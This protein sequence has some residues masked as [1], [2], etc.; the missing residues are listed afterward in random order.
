LCPPPDVLTGREGQARRLLPS[1]TGPVWWDVDFF[2]LRQG[3]GL[4]AVLGR[5]RAVAAPAADDRSMEL[6]PAPLPEKL[7][8][9]RQLTARRYGLRLLVGESPLVGCLA[10]QVRLAAAVTAPVLLVGPPGC[11]KRTVARVIHY[12]SAGRERAFAVL[13]AAR[14]PPVALAA[15]L[16]TDRSVGTVYI[17]EPARLPREFQ[18]KLAGLLTEADAEHPLPRLLAG[19]C[20]DPLEEVRAGHLLDELYTSFSALTIPVPPLT[21]RRE[22]LPRLV[23]AMLERLHEDGDRVVRG[24]TPE[25]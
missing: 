18:A 14:L 16:F 7:L 2:P 6:G 23:T 19:C 25:A 15:V 9:L 4:L 20:R 13:D 12:Q 17:R 10:R 24:L 1:R 3:D 22:E 5:V 11:G 8:T 21:A